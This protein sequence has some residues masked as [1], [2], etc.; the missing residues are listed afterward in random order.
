MDLK[1]SGPRPSNSRLEMEFR[2]WH[3][4]AKARGVFHDCSR[5]KFKIINSSIDVTPS[6]HNC[7]NNKRARA[8]RAWRREAIKNRSTVIG[9][10][11][12][13]KQGRMFGKIGNFKQHSGATIL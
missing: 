12:F 9:M 13:Q 8:R 4:I 3:A 1:T 7:Q 5:T 6:G 2:S 10:N 11:S